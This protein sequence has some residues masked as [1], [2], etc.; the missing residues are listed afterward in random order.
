MNIQTVSYQSR[1]CHAAR[2]QQ[3]IVLNGNKL[4]KDYVTAEY[5]VS[6]EHACRPNNPF[7]A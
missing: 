6:R 3:H 4:K 1:Q 2:T 5:R 7:F